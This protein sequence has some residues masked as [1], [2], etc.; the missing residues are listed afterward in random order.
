MSAAA[1]LE[2]KAYKLLKAQDVTDFIWGFNPS[3]VVEVQ[4]HKLVIRAKVED[5]K[6][7]R[8]N[9][10]GVSTHTLSFLGHLVSKTVYQLQPTRIEADKKKVVQ[11]H[12]TY[13]HLNDPSP[14]E[15]VFIIGTVLHSQ[16]G[17]H[18]LQFCV[19]SD[20]K[21]NVIFGTGSS[22]IAAFP[23]K[24]SVTASSTRETVKEKNSRDGYSQT[25]APTLLP[26]G[27]ATSSSSAAP[28][29]TATT[30]QPEPAKTP[31]ATSL[32]VSSSQAGRPSI[33]RRPGTNGSPAAKRR[34]VSF[35][36][37]GG[38]E[39]KT[40]MI[41]GIRQRQ[42][43]NSKEFEKMMK[44]MGVSP[45][46]VSIEALPVT[47]RRCFVVYFTATTPEE[48]SKVDNFIENRRW[49]E[50]LNV[51]YL[52]SEESK[53][54]VW[55]AM[56]IPT[57][58]ESLFLSQRMVQNPQEDHDLEAQLMDKQFLRL[59]T[60]DASLKEEVLSG[61]NS[62]GKALFKKQIESHTPK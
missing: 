31:A 34:R 16:N 24:P 20:P 2:K 28:R 54:F 49:H 46:N 42:T 58:I 18:Q 21:K 36:E 48:C 55:K 14:G 25:E 1:D 11:N 53:P 22:S 10:V 6:M 38:S 33:L 5:L 44:E 40:Y 52:C 23:P 56:P 27:H 13:T 17:I 60:S 12:L 35:A 3:S 30:S 15:E 51:V 32:A 37:N 59:A 45:A 61:L 29:P 50:F 8:M 7:D 19:E 9:G 4:R 26:S 41:V 47:R 39:K 43:A 57:I 62:K